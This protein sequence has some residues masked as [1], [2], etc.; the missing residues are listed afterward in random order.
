[1]DKSRIQGS[2]DWDKLLE[3]FLGAQDKE[4]LSMIFQLFMTTS[5]RKMLVD[6][7]SLVKALLTTDLSQRKI[8]DL[9]NLSISKITAGSKATKNLSIEFRK[10]LIKKMR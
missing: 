1:M 6:R 8:S 10:Y 3:L 7:Y 9:L 4:T 5:E 2:Q